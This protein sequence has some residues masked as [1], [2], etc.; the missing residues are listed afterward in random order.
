M[1]DFET[2]GDGYVKSM[3]IINLLTKRT[4]ILEM[5]A[6]AEWSDIVFKQMR[7]KHYLENPDYLNWNGGSIAYETWPAVMG[8]LVDCEQDYVYV[9]NERKRD[10]LN[11]MGIDKVI[12]A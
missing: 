1:I 12:V 8:K 7:R 2:V 4:F 11:L 6:P 9:N 3:T 5:K 10:L